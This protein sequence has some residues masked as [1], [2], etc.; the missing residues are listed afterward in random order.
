MFQ[1][2][3]MLAIVCP[4][5]MMIACLYLCLFLVYFYDMVYC[6]ADAEGSDEGKNKVNQILDFV[7]SLISMNKK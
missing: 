6:V 4:D 2:L 3:E 5:T 1:F 7:Y